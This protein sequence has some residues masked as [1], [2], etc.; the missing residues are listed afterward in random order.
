M[1]DG[2]SPSRE[3]S[4]TAPNTC[5]CREVGLEE[6]VYAKR[7]SLQIGIPHRVV[8]WRVGA[9]AARDVRPDCSIGVASAAIVHLVKDRGHGEGAVLVLD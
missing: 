7:D 2:R 6:P 4:A 5:L 8:G 9:H 3:L 1:C